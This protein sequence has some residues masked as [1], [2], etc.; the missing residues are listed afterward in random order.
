MLKKFFSVVIIFF[1]LT[2]IAHAEDEKKSVWQPEIRVG[3]KSGVKQVALQVSKP[4]VMINAAKGNVLKKIPAGGKFI[5]DF[6]HLKIN[7]IEIRPEKVPLK[8][9]QTTIDDKK[10]YGGVTVNKEKDSLTVINLAP[11]EEYLRGVL[12]KEMSPSFPLEALKAQAVAARTF[13]MNNRGKHSAEGYDI[14]ATTHCQVYDGATKYDSI[15][16]VID[17]TRGMVLTYKNKLAETN[18][19]GDSGGMTES[20]SDV[21]G[22]AV[23]YLV[24]VKE[25]L[26][27]AES[28]TIK[29]AAKDF[30]SRFGD[31]FGDV[32]SIKLSKLE[33]GKSAD[34]RTSSGR[35]KSAQVVSTKKTLTITGGDLRHKFSLPSTLFDMK[36]DGDE[37]IFTGYGSGHGVGM[38]QVGA[39]DYAKNGWSYEK[40]LEHYYSGAKLKKL[41]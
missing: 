17:E 2:S 18:F 23:P 36:L 3:L 38:S 6:E 33:V 30:S 4:C 25:V 10:Y 21:W 16:K 41:Y 1:V 12:A 26:K 24:A 22:T 14:C 20:V 11:L 13:A 15:D 39:K 27:T 19:H 40:I 5:V 31:G 9:L 37:I 34:D 28:W 7:A 32:K 35:V 8:D 29:V